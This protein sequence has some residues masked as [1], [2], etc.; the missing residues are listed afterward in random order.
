M[1]ALPTFII[2]TG[3]SNAWSPLQYL[4]ASLFIFGSVG[5]WRLAAWRKASSLKA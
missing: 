5:M 4:Q 2:V 3:R 1:A